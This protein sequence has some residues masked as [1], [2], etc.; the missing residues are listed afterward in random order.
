LVLYINWRKECWA[1]VLNTG[2]WVDTVRRIWNTNKGEMSRQRG[3]GKEKKYNKLEELMYPPLTF[4]MEC[5]VK[6]E[7]SRRGG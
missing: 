4:P 5:K 7:A 1:G 3:K 6:E 2:I